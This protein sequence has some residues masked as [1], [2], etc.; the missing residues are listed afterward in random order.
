MSVATPRGRVDSR[1]KLELLA[2]MEDTSVE[3][4]LEASSFDGI[5]S[6]ICMNEGC[7]YA[8]TLEPDGEGGHC[9]ECDTHSVKSCLV[10][11]GVI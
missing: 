9:P 10:I 5:A 6:A 11:A 4:M 3:S 1:T 8:T 2:H 7:D